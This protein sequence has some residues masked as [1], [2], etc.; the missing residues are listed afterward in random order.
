MRRWGRNG[1]AKPVPLISTAYEIVR[2][3]ALLEVLC[4]TAAGDQAAGEGGIA[5][6]STFVKRL[7]PE[8]DLRNR[9]LQILRDCGVDGATPGEDALKRFDSR[10]FHLEVGKHCRR[11]YGQKNYFRAVFEAAKVYNNLVKQKAQSTKDG[12]ALM[13]ARLGSV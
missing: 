4:H 8:G 7:A 11:L 9:L 5:L 3:R 2:N 13:M 10:R 6:L 12:E 1:K